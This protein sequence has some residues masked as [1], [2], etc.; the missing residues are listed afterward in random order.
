MRRPEATRAR[1]E[2]PSAVE[3]EAEVGVELFA[4][5]KSSVMRRAGL[6]DE[7]AEGIVVVGNS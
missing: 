2:I 6:V 3:V 5:V 4:R 1:V 7:N